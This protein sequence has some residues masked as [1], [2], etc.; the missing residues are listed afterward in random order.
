MSKAKW[1]NELFKNIDIIATKYNKIIGILYNG[2]D[3]RIYKDKIEVKSV[4]PDL[5]DKQYYIDLYLNTKIDKDR[6]YDLTR[7]INNRLHVEFK[8]NGVYSLCIGCSEV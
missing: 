1:E 3:V 4:A 7:L 2:K 8:M 6:I 5:Q